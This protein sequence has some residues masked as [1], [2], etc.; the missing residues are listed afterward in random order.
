[1]V[2]VPRTTVTE[3]RSETVLLDR[4]A[5]R[6]VEVGAPGPARAMLQGR[7]HHRGSINLDVTLAGPGWRREI[8]VKRLT[9]HAFD[10]YDRALAAGEVHGVTMMSD[11]HRRLAD[12]AVALGAIGAMVTL[13]GRADWFAVDVDSELSDLDVLVLHRVMQPT[14]AELLACRDGSDVAMRA[15]H[16]LGA[17]AK[18][19]HE[20]TR[21]DHAV[22]H[23]DSRDDVSALADRLIHSIGDSELARWQPRIADALRGLPDDMP[24]GPTHGV[25]RANNVFVD[26]LGAVAVFDTSADALSPPHLDLARLV[27][28]LELAAVRPSI[29]S[30]GRRRSWAAEL[31]KAAVDGYGNNAPSVSERRLFE[32]I[33]LLDQ[34]AAISTR[35]SRSVAPIQLAKRVRRN[36]RVNQVRRMLRERL[37][38][39]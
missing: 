20:T 10:R 24:I 39:V 11:P 8:F 33:V 7:R 2:A 6:S 22:R 34:W 15:A 4:L 31:A 36:M 29:R 25:L 5:G 3:D 13:S 38:T 12:E 23:M 19:F 9:P 18:A 35:R 30:G 1:M 32:M 26:Q 21:L 14:L 27:V 17:W 37:V 16:A 28:D